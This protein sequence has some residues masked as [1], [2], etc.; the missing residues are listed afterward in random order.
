MVVKVVVS[1][2]VPL[3]YTVIPRKLAVVVNEVL[4]QKAK[5]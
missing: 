2:V 1:V 4:Y 3:L 5:G